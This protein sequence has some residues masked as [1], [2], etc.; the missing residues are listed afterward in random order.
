MDR[1]RTLRAP[2]PSRREAATT[3]QVQQR[4]ARHRLAGQQQHR[5]VDLQP[6]GPG[7]APAARVGRRRRRHRGDQRHDRP[8]PAV[9]AAAHPAGGR[10]P[11]GLLVLPR[12][13]R[14]GPVDGDRPG[15]PDRGHRAAA[16]RAVVRADD[17][18]PDGLRP[19]SCRASWIRP[20]T[21]SAA[22]PHHLWRLQLVAEWCAG[23]SAASHPAGDCGSATPTVLLGLCRAAGPRAA[24]PRGAFAATGSGPRDPPAVTVGRAS[25]GHGARSVPPPPRRS[26][27]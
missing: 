15:L 14:P 5:R 26:E 12:L 3:R 9:P 16:G 13:V 8:L 7:A 27:T 10:R 24:P 18:R 17:R 2:A 11:G 20:R 21:A 25:V 6:A 23:R 1:R 4:R 22:R 19:A